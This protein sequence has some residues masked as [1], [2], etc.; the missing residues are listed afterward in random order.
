MERSGAELHVSSLLVRESFAFG[1]VHA[2]TRGLLKP[3]Y[4]SLPKIEFRFRVI[5]GTGII[6]QFSHE[7]LVFRRAF[8]TRDA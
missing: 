2:V 3:T 4:A 7:L 6:P 5:I 8:N 1:T